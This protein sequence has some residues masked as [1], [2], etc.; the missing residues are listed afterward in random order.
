MSLYY[1]SGLSGDQ[2]HEKLMD[3]ID[4]DRQRAAANMDLQ[5]KVEAISLAQTKSSLLRTI[6]SKLIKGEISGEEALKM[7]RSVSTI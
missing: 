4:A 1:N 3:E 2:L 7:M 5:L 6:Q